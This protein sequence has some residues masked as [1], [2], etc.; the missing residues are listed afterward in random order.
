VE[1]ANRSF[2]WQKVHQTPAC[3]ANWEKGFNVGGIPKAI[4][5]VGFIVVQIALTI[6]DLCGEKL[7]I[8]YSIV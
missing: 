1:S 2:R 4:D 8:L 3:G 6:C 7:R 5:E